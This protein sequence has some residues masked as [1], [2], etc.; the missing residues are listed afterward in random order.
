M[1]GTFQDKLSFYQ[2]WKIKYFEKSCHDYIINCLG[3][4]Q[5]IKIIFIKNLDNF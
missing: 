5:R 4:L 3:D 2:S 1:Y